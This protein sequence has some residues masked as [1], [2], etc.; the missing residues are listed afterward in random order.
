M[1]ELDFRLLISSLLKFARI[2]WLISYESWHLEK[3]CT[4]MNVAANDPIVARIDDVKAPAF[5]RE[6]R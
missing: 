3:I 2:N 4:T 1:R 5:F 6:C